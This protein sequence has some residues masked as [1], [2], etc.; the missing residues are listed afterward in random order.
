MAPYGNAELLRKQAKRFIA[1]AG[2]S[3]RARRDHE[4]RFPTAS[5]IALPISGVDGFFLFFSQG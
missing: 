2:A 5:P 3:A 1:S 4:R